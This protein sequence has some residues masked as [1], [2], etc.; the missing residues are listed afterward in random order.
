MKK[1]YLILVLTFS[2]CL[3]YVDV[4]IVDEKG[5]LRF[6][7]GKL[8]SLIENDESSVRNYL[9]IIDDE[10][11]NLKAY[12]FP[13]T[14]HTKGT[15]GTSH[16]T[17]QQIYENIPV[18]GRYVRIH[19]K[20]K[21]I[22]SISNNIININLNI[23]PSIT[24]ASSIDIVKRQAFATSNYV[25]YQKIQIYIIKESAHLVHTIDLIDFKSPWRFMV[26]AHSGE[27]IDKFPLFY[28]NGP[29]LGNGINL[30]NQSIDIIGKK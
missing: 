29:V 2:F 14:Y 11:G 8:F 10:L 22:T 5:M 30:L 26:D 12:Q 18:F 17:F 3:A 23:I 28:D 4:K 27:I 15:N 16:Y 21:M 6:S 13:I 24:Y 1:Y 19:E 20:N 25:K 7:S 9:K